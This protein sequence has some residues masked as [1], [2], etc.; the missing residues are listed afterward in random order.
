MPKFRVE[1]EEKQTTTRQKWIDAD[2]QEE[3]RTLAEAEDW[4][5]W[6]VTD[7]E[8]DTSIVRIEQTDPEDRDEQL[9]WD[10]LYAKHSRI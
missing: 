9:Y 2:S 5:T 3:A 1:V 8:T 10:S 4:R 7:E 6:E